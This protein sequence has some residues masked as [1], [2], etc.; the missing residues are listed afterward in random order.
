MQDLQKTTKLV[1]M[2]DGVNKV[3]RVWGAFGLREVMR[4]TMYSNGNP[5]QTQLQQRSWFNAALCCG[6]WRN[7]NHFPLITVIHFTSSPLYT[8]ALLSGIKLR[9]PPCV[10]KWGGLVWSCYWNMDQKSFEFSHYKQRSIIQADQ[11]RR[12]TVMTEEHAV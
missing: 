2:S 1:I 4:Q 3:K 6:I 11:W 5:S 10:D 12:Q 8:A 9:Q 7:W